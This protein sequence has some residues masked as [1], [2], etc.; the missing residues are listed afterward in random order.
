[1]P[2]VRRW[3]GRRRGCRTWCPAVSGRPTHPG[4]PDAVT[5]SVGT[6][7]WRVGPVRRGQDR[8]DQFEDAMAVLDAFHVVRLGTTTVSEAP[9]RVQQDTLWNRGRKGDPLFSG[10]R[11]SSVPGRRT[12]SRCNGPGRSRRSRPT[13]RTTEAPRPSVSL[14]LAGLGLAGQDGCW[15]FQLGC[16]SRSNWPATAVSF[17]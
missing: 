5:C 3:V 9:R 10:S 14:A 6:R 4:S 1:V 8:D 17:R 13:K 2:I 16:D 7:W 12:S 11:P 15:S